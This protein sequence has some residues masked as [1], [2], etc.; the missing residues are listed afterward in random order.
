MTKT[1]AVEAFKND[2]PVIYDGIEYKC[3]SAI[4]YRRGGPNG[5]YAQLELL[6]RNR[7]D[8]IIADPRR[9]MVWEADD[10]GGRRGG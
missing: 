3:I 6:D 2:L 10:V 4:I 9:V 8:V 5:I 7:R 1:E